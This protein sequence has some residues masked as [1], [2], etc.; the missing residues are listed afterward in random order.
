M[1][2]V[3]HTIYVHIVFDKFFLMY[4]V[5]SMFTNAALCSQEICN[6]RGD[7]MCG[8]C[9]CQDGYVGAQCKFCQST[10]DAVSN[11]YCTYIRM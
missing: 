3:V 7:C 1:C 9:E 11:V 4:Y 8:R 10:T 6:G 2:T 5:F